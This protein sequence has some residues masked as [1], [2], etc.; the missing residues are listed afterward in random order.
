MRYLDDS[1]YI[2]WWSY[3]PQFIYYLDKSSNPPVKR[4]YYIDFKFEDIKGK[5]HWVE[6]KDSKECHKPE[7][8]NPRDMLIWIKN[9]SKWNAAK[10]LAESRGYK[11]SIITE[12]ELH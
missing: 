3:E 8:N 2:R 7:N 5:I 1:E 6:V 12:K 10:V 4:K 11:F 9:T